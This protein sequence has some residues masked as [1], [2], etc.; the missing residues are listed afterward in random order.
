MLDEVSSELINVTI[1]GEVRIY[2]ASLLMPYN[3]SVFVGASSNDTSLFQN[4][5]GALTYAILDSSG[6]LLQ[7]TYIT[8][9]NN[10]SIDFTI[11]RID[12]LNVSRFGIQLEA[13]YAAVSGKA[14]AEEA[15]YE[16]W[17]FYMQRM[18]EDF[19]HG[20]VYE[21]EEFVSYQIGD[22]VYVLFRNGSEDVCVGG[23]FDSAA[24]SCS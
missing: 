21:A 19:S 14:E 1:A 23:Y 4:C 9:F 17:L 20:M 3:L 16:T 12:D 22:V 11:V 2:D 18:R 6:D 5:S 10:L 15:K 24:L 7:P 8:N 13:E